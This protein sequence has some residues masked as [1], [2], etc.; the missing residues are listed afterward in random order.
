MTDA[1]LRQLRIEYELAPIF[2]STIFD[3]SLSAAKINFKD[4][5]IKFET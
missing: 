1:S 3:V 4:P 2:R 5:Y